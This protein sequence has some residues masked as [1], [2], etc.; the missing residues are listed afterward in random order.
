MANMTTARKLL[1][2]LLGGSSAA[3]DRNAYANKLLGLF[4][5]NIVSYVPLWESAGLNAMD[6][7]GSNDGTYS[8][9]GVSYAQTGIGDGRTSVLLD[10][11]A[12][13]INMLTAVSGGFNGAEGTACFWF[14]V[15]A[16]SWTDGA[17]RY[18]LIFRVSASHFVQILKSSVNGRLEYAYMAGGT[19]KQYRR[20]GS[21]ETAWC[22]C[23]IT[24]SKS[25][26]RV[27]CYFNGA[28]VGATLTALG[29]WSGAL[30]AA[31]YGANVGLSNYWTDN[32]AHMILLDREATAAEIAAA[33]VIPVSVP[34]SQP[35]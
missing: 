30:V 12:G 16:G 10:G 6:W 35:F 31:I 14:K 24:W 7:A 13:N 9:S 8:A 17:V 4:G 1:L 26:D 20:E 19:Q 33:H 15:E 29:T 22:S 3:P 5:A 21:N 34:D 11:S 25:N 28:Q 23:A 2:G 27:I 18:L 32:L